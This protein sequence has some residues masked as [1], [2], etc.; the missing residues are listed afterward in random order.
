MNKILSK[1]L[2]GVCLVFLFAGISYASSISIRLQQ[3]TSQ[4]GQNSFDLT[5]VALDTQGGNVTVQC[6]KK[7]PLDATFV[8]FGSPIILTGDGNTDV[9]HVDSSIVNQTGYTYKFRATATGASGTAPSNEVSVSYNNEGPGTP[10]DYNKSKPDSCNY[11]ITF[12]TANDGGKT[13]KVV[14]YR[15]DNASFNLDSGTQ[16]STLSIG[17]DTNGEFLN[18]IPDCDKTYYYALRAFDAYG[19]ASGS[20]GDS[21]TQTTT[22]NV[23]G[24]PAEGALVVAGGGQVLGGET[25]KSGEEV[26]GTESAKTTPTVKP[27]QNP[28]SASANWILGHKKISLTVLVIIIVVAYFLYRR[29]RKR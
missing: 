27:G 18:S 11:K 22:V 1:I 20:I 21:S 17:S 26:L 29:Y 7:G 2:L 6:E 23:T 9:C 12:K 25:T 13:V 16:V 19:N 4:T 24:A 15:S 14:L 5:F 28:V 10:V 8:G 3:P